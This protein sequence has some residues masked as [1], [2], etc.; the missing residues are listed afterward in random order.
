MRY[1]IETFGCNICVQLFWVEEAYKK[2]KCGIQQNNY[3]KRKMVSHKEDSIKNKENVKPKP[4]KKIFL[5]IYN[6]ETPKLSAKSF[7]GFGPKVTIV[8]SLILK[9]KA[10]SGIAD[11]TSCERDA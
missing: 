9:D 6:T 8:R 11:R 1:N 10:D 3:L 4:P 5:E 2:H 7:G